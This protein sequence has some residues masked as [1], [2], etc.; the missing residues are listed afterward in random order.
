MSDSP[1]SQPAPTNQ[2]QGDG[3]AVFLSD[4]T[5]EEYA[6][7]DRDQQRGWAGFRKKLGL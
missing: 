7:Y 5:D 3:Q 1:H 4:M 6:A 2:P